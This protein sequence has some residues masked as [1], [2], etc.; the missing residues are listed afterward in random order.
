M[1]FFPLNL[2]Y[3]FFE[4]VTYFVSSIDRLVICVVHVRLSIVNSVFVSQ[5]KSN[6]LTLKRIYRVTLMT[7]YLINSIVK[8]VF[9]NIIATQ[10]SNANR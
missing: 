10:V 3:F 7:T 6:F 9:D 4:K 5:L 1:E 2:L 8:S